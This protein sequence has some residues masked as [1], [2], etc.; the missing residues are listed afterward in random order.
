MEAEVY[1]KDTPMLL[2]F[3]LIFL[4]IFGIWLMK[5]VSSYDFKN[6]S[7]FYFLWNNYDLIGGILVGLGLLIAVIIF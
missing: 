4:V 6:E 1:I 3:G 7:T 5:R 2:L